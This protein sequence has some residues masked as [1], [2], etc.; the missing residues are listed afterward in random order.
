MVLHSRAYA[1]LSLVIISYFSRMT[2][3]DSEL[4]AA[5]TDLWRRNLLLKAVERPSEKDRLNPK[6]ARRGGA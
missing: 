6:G 2:D 3:E 1:C 5:Y 4:A